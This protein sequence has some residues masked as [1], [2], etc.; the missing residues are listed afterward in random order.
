[1]KK[2]DY[3]TPMMFA[4]TFVANQYV[5]ACQ[6]PA[7]NITETLTVKCTSPGHDNTAVNVMFTDSMSACI[8]KFNPGV[9]EAKGDKFYTQFE[10]CA[11]VV[12]CNKQKWLEKYPHDKN[13]NK[14]V[15][16]HGTPDWDRDGFVMH[17]TVID[18]RFAEKYQLS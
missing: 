5:A 4:E 17:D 6:N 1:M 7:Y 12:G 13:F 3:E 9:G 15:K 18:L 14:H 11:Y 16:R 10:A 8:V 2:L